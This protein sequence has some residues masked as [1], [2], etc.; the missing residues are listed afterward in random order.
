MEQ[1]PPTHTADVWGWVAEQLTTASK[2]P[3]RRTFPN[4]SPE[5][6]VAA[7]LISRAW[8]IQNQGLEHELA[9]FLDKRINSLIRNNFVV[10]WQWDVTIT[11]WILERAGLPELF[12]RNPTLAAPFLKGSG[13]TEY[14]ARQQP[15]KGWKSGI[16]SLLH[17]TLI[18]GMKAEDAGH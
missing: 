11:A 13:I 6:H 8:D 14:I 1:E 5:A 17:D 10:E 15:F 9:N 4:T 2:G 7:D 18:P 16:P 3:N 12:V